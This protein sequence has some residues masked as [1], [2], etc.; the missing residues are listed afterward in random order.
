V[1]GQ[2]T[3][4]AWKA[5]L[6]GHSIEQIGVSCSQIAVRSLLFT[7]CSSWLQLGSFNL[8]APSSLRLA[9]TSLIQRADSQR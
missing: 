2:S 1:C 7:V 4:L 3:W 8:A 6:Y 5:A 9:W